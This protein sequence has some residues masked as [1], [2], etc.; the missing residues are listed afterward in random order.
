MLKLDFLLGT[1]YAV[2]A[3]VDE[4][5]NLD[6][7]SE[8]GARLDAD[9][10]QAASKLL[11]PAK[12]NDEGYSEHI[13]AVAIHLMRLMGRDSTEIKQAARIINCAKPPTASRLLWEPDTDCQPKQPPNPFF[14]FLRDGDVQAATGLLLEACPSPGTPAAEPSYWIW[15][16]TGENLDGRRSMYW[17]CI[18][19]GRLLGAK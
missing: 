15:E 10:G 14:L 2:M 13:V 19:M 8:F 1:D 12:F 6:G 17:D 5:L 11:V 4:Y 16:S 18:F 9:R 7:A 3:E